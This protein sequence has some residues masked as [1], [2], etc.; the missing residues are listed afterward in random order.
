VVCRYP[1]A[2]NADK[3]GILLIVTAGKDGALSGG[4]SFMAAIGDDF[5][6]SVVGENIP[7]LTQEEKY[8]ECLAS[9]SKRIEAVLTG[10]T[11][12]GP[13]IRQEAERRRTY[14]T[15]EEVEKTKS[16]STTVVGTLLFISVV[17]PMLQYYGYTSKD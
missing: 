8:N 2:E 11:D 9:I 15:K 4:K 5:I 12:P 16:V 14:K 10:G 17:V 6:D 13:P 1:S 7:I 3:K